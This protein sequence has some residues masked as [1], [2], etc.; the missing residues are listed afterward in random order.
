MPQLLT[1]YHVFIASPGGLG[2]LRRQFRDVVAKYNDR[3]AIRRGVLF[4]PVGWEDTLGGVGRPQAL[5][6]RQLD[7]CDYFL[8]VLHDR[9]GSDPG[10]GDG[11]SGSE[12]EFNLARRQWEN[13]F[14][15][16]RD[17]VVFFKDP[18]PDR[19]SDPGAQLTK[20][21]DFRKGL[22]G[23]KKI[24]FH[25]FSEVDH[26][27]E[28]LESHLAEWVRD[29]EERVSADRTAHEGILAS[30]ANLHP[31][32]AAG[33][34]AL[35]P[36]GP[37]GP[38]LGRPDVTLTEATRLWGAG[39]LTEAELIFASL[40]TGGDD[41]A[42]LCS[43]AEF[44]IATER[45]GQAEA[46]F[47]RAIAAAVA[48]ADLSWEARAEFG[49]GMALVTQV[50]LDEGGT[51]LF[52]SVEAHRQVGPSREAARAALEYADVLRQSG[53]PSS[54]L[55]NVESALTMAEIL[56]DVSLAADA[57]AG[58]GQQR[59]DQGEPELARVDLE[60]AVARKRAAGTS[61]DF[62]D[63]LVSLGDC[64]QRIGDLPAA[65]DSYEE[66]RSFLE[67]RG[68]DEQVADML[69]NLG[70]V[71]ELL[72]DAARAEAA[73]QQAAERFVQVQKPG[74]AADVLSSV[75]KLRERSG[76]PD[77]ALVTYDSAFIYATQAADKAAIA[78]IYAAMEVLV[79]EGAKRHP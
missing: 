60:Q 45:Y 32:A 78:E 68:L 14:K 27:A 57:L 54:A 43:F 61:G 67:G 53:E 15:P 65:R 12:E 3:D 1:A 79:R 28:R 35:V 75:A 73:Y 48:G 63:I 20:V 49:L 76:D 59:L 23:E 72:G 34:S 52:R 2:D 18:G 22:E 16:M 24:L 21:V 64:L 13:G 9:W 66:A 55:S 74:A 58:R 6:N 51:H 41:A 46:M 19:L 77:A 17:L 4:V 44:L 47:G 69:D 30:V 71:L 5:I 33:G 8:L 36:A 56:G 39:N 62:G 70:R 11:T 7:V 50:Q 38:P 40:T 37:A 10:G 25:V 42:A 29:H 31:K 26:F